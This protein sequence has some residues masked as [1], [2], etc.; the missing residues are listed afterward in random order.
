MARSKGIA[1]PITGINA[2]LRKSIKEA[3][4]DL[5]AFGKASS[6]W[7]K[8]QGLYY[9]IAGAAAVKFGEDVV[10]TA[11]EDERSQALLAKQLQNTT[12]A[13][14]AQIKGAEDYIRTTMDAT[15]ITDDDL[16]PALAKLVRVTKDQSEAQKL[17]TLATD[18]SIG[19][20]RDLNSVTTALSR[21]YIGNYTALTRLGIVIDKGRASTEGFAAVQDQLNQQFGGAAAAAADT[22]AGRVKNLT[23]RWHELKEELGKALLPVVDNVVTALA[24]AGDVAQKTH[25]PFAG[26]LSVITSAGSG[27]ENFISSSIGLNQ[28]GDEIVKTWDMVYQDVFGDQK[29]IDAAN[30]VSELAGQYEKLSAILVRDNEFYKQTATY[31]EDQ[32]DAA[33]LAERQVGYLKDQYKLLSDVT[34]KQVD[35]QKKADEERKKANE[36]QRKEN[37]RLDKETKAKHKAAKIAYQE[38]AKILRE[39]LAGALQA[40]REELKRAQEEADNFGK[41]LAQSFGVSLS[42]AYSAAKD[43]EDAYTSALKGRQDAYAA[44]DVAKQGN[45]LNAYLKAVQDVA[46]AEQAVT[47]A[48]KARVTPAA[49]F[50]KQ[51]EDAKNFGSNL[52]TLIGQGL[53]QAGLQQLLDLGPTAGAEVTKAL[54]DGTAGFTV[55]DLNASLQGLADVQSGLAASITNQLAPKA[56]ITSAQSMVDALSSA[57]IAAPGVGQGFTI[58]ITAGVGDPVEIGRQVKQV[59]SDYDNRAGSLIVQGG[60]KKGKK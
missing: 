17:L 14:D 4:K 52:K 19:S 15:N 56:G 42:D 21:A 48:Q 35:D 54:L 12:N 8:A 49:A 51:I 39:D 58:N 26:L 27:I 31:I 20:G 16:R 18:V 53:G 24:D 23:I 13:R 37:D 1:I 47:D 28:V 45:D 6:A 10:R 50:Q 2:P 29:Q 38:K 44:L 5:T 25:N 57:S 22:V 33:A 60:K 40:A 7:S 41:S 32:A 55:S 43:G 30:A 3:Q 46:T 11:L 59:L 9:G 34:L 36:E